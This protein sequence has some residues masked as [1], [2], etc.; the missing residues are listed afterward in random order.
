MYFDEIYQN[1]PK[2]Y[3]KYSSWTKNRMSQDRKKNWF[4]RGGLGTSGHEVL[5]DRVFF[6]SSTL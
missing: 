4:N 1:N 2:K 3:L 6:V 5:I